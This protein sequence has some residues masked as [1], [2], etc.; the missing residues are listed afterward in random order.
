MT[1][2]LAAFSE[3]IA[4]AVAAVAP[5]VVQVHGRR[6][7]VSGVA[8]AGG[9]VITS[10]RALGRDDKVGITT[11]DGRTV[12]AELAGWDPASGLALLR[13]DGLDLAEPAAAATAP[14]VGH[15]VLAVARSWS[16]ALTASAGVIAVIGGPLR[17]GRGRSLEQV[18]RITAPMHDGFAG[19]AVLD[20]G[21]GLVG[22]A[23]AATIRGYGVVIPVAIAKKSAAYVLEHG[24]PRVGFL[25]LSGQT[26]TLPDRQRVEPH[27]TGL[28]VVGVAKDAPA[29]AAGLLVGDIVVAL[30]GKPV[31]STEDLLTLLTADRVGRQ[32][33]LTVLR[34]GAAVDVPVTIGE[35][36]ESK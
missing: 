36:R 29:D 16:N 34:G 1:T 2:T 13:A 32:V 15:V 35:R 25:G 11:M 7:S 30:D 14:R 4:N 23:T 33:P 19:G 8:Q 28:L 20:A 26:V 6:R 18:L 12:A 27:R 17:T 9:I 31:G 3:D 24:R 22:I 10:A 21:G 5:A